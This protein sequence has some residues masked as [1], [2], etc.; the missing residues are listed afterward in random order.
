MVSLLPIFKDD[1][2]NLQLLQSK[3]KGIID[4]ILSNPILA[5]L[6]INSVTISSGHAAIIN[7]RLDRKQQGWFIV[8][9]NA[10]ANIARIQP[11]NDKTLTL[12]SDAAVTVAVWVY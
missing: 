7:H 2:Q 5:G 4:P 1:N 10:P 3:W 9:Q 12:S 11:L 8:D 6:Q